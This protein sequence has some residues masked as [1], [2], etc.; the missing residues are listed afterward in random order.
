MDQERRN[1]IWAEIIQAAKEQNDPQRDDEITVRQF[2]NLLKDNGVV[3]SRDKA[4]KM[5]NDKVENGELKMRI[6]NRVHLF[7][8]AK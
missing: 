8:P 1:K 5:L 7:S 3:V 4:R 6:R 2:M